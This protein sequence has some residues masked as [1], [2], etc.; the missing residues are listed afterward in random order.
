VMDGTGATAGG[1]GKAGKKRCEQT[2]MSTAV[3]VAVIVRRCNKVGRDGFVARHGA[4][5]R[6]ANGYNTARNSESRINNCDKTFSCM[7]Q[8]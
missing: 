4:Q 7:H 1:R 3:V 8:I 2:S 5:D 6:A